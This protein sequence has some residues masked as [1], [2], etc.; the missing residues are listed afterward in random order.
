MDF[1]LETYGGV[2]SHENDFE[3]EFGQPLDIKQMARLK[4]IKN[5]KR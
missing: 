2:N 5:Q 4:E 3:E 1:L